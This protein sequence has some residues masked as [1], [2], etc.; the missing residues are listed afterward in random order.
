MVSVVE[1]T[2]LTAMILFLMS[3]TLDSHQLLSAMRSPIPVVFA[4]AINVG[5]LPLASIPFSTLQFSAD[6]SIGLVIACSVPCTMA[7]ASVW[8][9]N[10]GGNDAVS[11]LVTLLTNGLC[12]V[13]TPFWI[14][15]ALGSQIELD[16]NSLVQRLVITA[17][18]PSLAGQILRQF[19]VLRT[20]AIRWK[21]A[22]GTAALAGILVI[23]FRSA[24]L[25][26]DQLLPGGSSDLSIT[27]LIVCLI[28]CNILH[29]SAMGVGWLGAKLLRVQT[30]DMI[31]ILFASSQKTLPIGVYLAT[32]P[33]AF[34][35]GPAPIAVFPI[36]A[37]HI[38]QLFL[39]TF[40]AARIRKN[41]S[42]ENARNS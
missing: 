35:I 22:L 34:S 40:I 31:A 16:P 19:A 29:V 9:R 21:L 30:E 6:L 32:L 13:I 5:F 3:F 18:I 14:S 25:N 1:V 26:A 27:G 28:C 24:V 37:F 15:V 33:G 17:L 23:V 2:W 20:F 12:F 39:D 11:L 36:I 42:S 8:T 38:S 7:A 4:C 10:A 41:R